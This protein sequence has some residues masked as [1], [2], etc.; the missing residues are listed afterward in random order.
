MPSF[1]KER[2]SYICVF[3]V[4]YAVIGSLSSVDDDDGLTGIL[5]SLW[6][7]PSCR[8]VDAVLAKMLVPLWRI[9][10]AVVACRCGVGHA[11]MAYE[12]SPRW[13]R[14]IPSKCRCGVQKWTLCP[15]SL[16]HYSVS[17]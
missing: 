9:V 16:I 1:R 3:P 14:L 11:V 10:S 4:M 12:G 8:I 15:P 5:M 2:G 7:G 17:R 13:Y 6:V